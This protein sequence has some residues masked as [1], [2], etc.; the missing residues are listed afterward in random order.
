MG[1]RYLIDTNVI[2]YFSLN[3]IQGKGKAFVADVIDNDPYISAINKIELLGFSVVPQEI[4]DFVNIAN[5][6]VM[7]DEVINQTIALRKTHKIKLP[8]AILLLQL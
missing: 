5:I 1:Q 2:I 4:I 3:L 6:I 7:T 8:D